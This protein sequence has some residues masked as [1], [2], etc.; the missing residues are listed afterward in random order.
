MNKIW[1]VTQ[2]EYL[3][4]VKNK[5]FILTTLLTPLGILVFMAAV[6]FVMSTGSDKAKTINVF[7]PTNLLEKE[8]ISRDNLTF[9][10]SNESL[11]AQKEL[12]KAKKINGI[13]EIPALTDSL[14]SKYSYKY[15]AD[16][17]LAMDESFAIDK[18]IGK[19][20]RNYKLKKLN[21]DETML[22][23]LDTDVSSIPVTILEDK[24]I[25]SITNV[26]SSV[27]GGVVGYAMFFII[28]FY[29]MQVMRS[30]MEEKINRIVE[31]LISSLKPF[32]L[33]M[34]KVIGVGLVG[35]TQIGIWLILMPLIYIIGAS[36]FG[37]N[38]D[39][40]G[41]L[42]TN[43]MP[44]DQ[45]ALTSQDK[46]SQ[47]FFELK[48]MNWW[49]ILPLTLFYFLGGYFAYSAIFA[50]I[51]SAVG[52]D[53]NDANSLTLPVMMPLMFS[54][55]I[56]ISA[57]N[58]PDSSLAVWSSMIPLL[59]SIVMPVRLPFDPPWW[60]IAISVV[61]LIIFSVLVVWLAARIYRVGILM[62]GK[63]ASFKEL[64]KWVFYKG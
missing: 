12:Y 24:K 10:F 45:M 36:L 41:S 9:S 42:A 64:A 60:Q 8:L 47:V 4:R 11:E 18:A 31:V 57:V 37:V 38:A 33:M 29:G 51:G 54:M 59:S 22:K 52:E 39:G 25:S 6:V 3:T 21:I 34:G 27:L 40:I 28:L 35:L 1:L 58:A 19:K 2:R 23:N 14:A 53:I 15:H 46:I 43:D 63:K 26:V 7:D 20:I 61:S 13:I 55:Y 44:I 17:P 49:L 48:S 62:Y 56:G 30:V 5:T 32:E 50:A 16:K